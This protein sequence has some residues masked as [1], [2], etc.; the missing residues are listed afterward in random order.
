LYDKLV[1]LS[2]ILLALTAAS[3][4]YRGHLSDID[5]RWNVIANSVDDRT[6]EEMGLKVRGA[7]SVHDLRHYCVPDL[8]SH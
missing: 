5:C 2:P 3:P 1:P 7:F 8:I 4:V 6:E